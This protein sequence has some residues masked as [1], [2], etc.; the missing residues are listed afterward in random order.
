MGSTMN[1]APWRVA[2]IFSSASRSLNGTSEKCVDS[3]PKP[4]KA[5]LVRADC[6]IELIYLPSYALNLNLIE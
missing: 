1:A 2:A 6:R 5:Y 4:F 3:D